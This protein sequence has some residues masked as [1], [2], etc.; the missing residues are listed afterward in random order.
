ML[1]APLLTALGALLGVLD[2]DVRLCCPAT[3][4]GRFPAALGR[5]EFSRLLAG[6]LLGGNDTQLL[7]CVPKNAARCWEGRQLLGLMHAAPKRLWPSPHRGAAVCDLVVVSALAWV[8][9]M[10]F[11]L[12]SHVPLASLTVSMG[13]DMLALL[14]WQALG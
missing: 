12:C 3:T 7:S 5:V 9:R 1:L 13:F 6:G 2:G 8:L 11:G 4:W 10:A 14:T